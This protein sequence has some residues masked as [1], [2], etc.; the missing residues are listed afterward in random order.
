MTMSVSRYHEFDYWFDWCWEILPGQ[1]GNK[2][3]IQWWLASGFWALEKCDECTRKEGVVSTFTWLMFIMQKKMVS[4]QVFPSLL[5][6]LMF[7]LHQK[8]HFPFPLKCLPHRLSDVSQSVYHFHCLRYI[9]WFGYF[10]GLKIT[11]SLNVLLILENQDWENG[12]GERK[13][14]KWNNGAKVSL[15][16]FLY[17]YNSS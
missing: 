9:K 15:N 16:R 12:D 5:N 13:Y 1:L 11:S 3:L 6:S 8:T 10:V 4:W 2:L 7:L 14:E 17:K